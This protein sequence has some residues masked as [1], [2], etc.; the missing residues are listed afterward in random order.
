MSHIALGDNR[1]YIEQMSENVKKLDTTLSIEG[2]TELAVSFDSIAKSDTSRWL[3]LY[4]ISYCNLLCSFIEKDNSIKDKYLDRSELYFDEANKKFTC[5][6]EFL[7]KITNSELYV[8]KAFIEM[9][10]VAA[11]KSMAMKYVKKIN[12][13][14]ETAFHYNPENPRIYLLKGQNLYYTPKM[15]GGGAK[16]ACPTLKEAAEKY[17][18]FKPEYDFSP[19]WGKAR[20]EELIENCN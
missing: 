1:D 19:H 18:S 14:L 10:R 8:L 4:Y 16:F 15:F 3:P 9:G 5:C 7:S 12:K 13:S 11:D 20:N 2:L 17:E 6:T